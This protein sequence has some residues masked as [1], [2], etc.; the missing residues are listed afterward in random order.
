MPLLQLGL[1]PRIIYQI[2]TSVPSTPT[3][4]PMAPVRTYSMATGVAVMRA[5]EWTV[6]AVSALVGAYYHM[7]TGPKN[8]A[9]IIYM[10]MTTLYYMISCLISKS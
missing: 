10:K 9:V 8:S 3:F 1:L 5:T 2:S 6:Q 4:V 7:V